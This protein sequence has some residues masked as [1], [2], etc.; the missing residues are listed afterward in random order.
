MRFE[1]LTAAHPRWEE[2]ARYAEEC[3]WHAGKALADDMRNGKFA[4]WERV[5]IAEEGESIRGF[6]TVA[7]RDC[8][9]DERYTPFIGFVF[10]DEKS[11]GHRLS[12]R[13]IEC[14]M[15]YLKQRGFQRVYLTSDHE[16]LYEKYGFRV[17]DRQ[18]AFWDGMEKVYTRELP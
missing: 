18:R 7:K 14:A 4:D 5:L 16:N 2:A 13:L 3:S 11:R 17:I 9:P 15:D 1:L 8:I 12:Q 6:C 10:V